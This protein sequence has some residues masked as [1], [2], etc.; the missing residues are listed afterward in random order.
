MACKVLILIT[1]TSQGLGLA[2]KD[3]FLDYDVI[4]INRIMQSEN[5]LEFDLSDKNF[6]FKKIKTR[7]QHYQKVVFISNASIIDPIENIINVDGSDIEDSIYVNYINPSRIILEILKS[8]S[9]YIVLNITSGAAFS[10]NT[11]LAL[12][13]SSK[14]AMHKFID[15]LKIEENYN[16]NALYIDNFDPGRMKTSMQRNLLY[17]KMVAI[18]TVELNEVKEVAKKI[19]DIL[20]AYIWMKKS[21]Y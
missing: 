11:K 10:N 7:I 19:Y 1:G 15:I 20:G 16:Q 8:N 2:L 14:A 5:D 12:Y 21:M 4:G 17:K 18:D 9:E 13:S 6:D 3:T